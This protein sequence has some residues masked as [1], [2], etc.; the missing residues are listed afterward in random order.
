MMA[1]L[2]KRIWIFMRTI[3]YWKLSCDN[4]YSLFLDDQRIPMDAFGF[5]SDFSYLG[6]EW[7]VVRNY[8]QFVK[9]IRRNFKD[10]K[11]PWRVSF[12]H[13]LC[14]EHTRWY[15]ENGGHANPPDPINAN[16]KEKSGMDCAKWLVE[17]CMDNNVRLPRYKVHSK[18]PCGKENIL[19]I[20]NSFK[21]HQ[22]NN[23]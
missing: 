21:K 6:R 1:A 16:F 23:E 14:L 10:G 2:I 18:N 12:D 8:G 3:P 5:S 15:F 4:G 9:Y 19:G 20:L 17:F 11:L 7:V 13:D 22:E